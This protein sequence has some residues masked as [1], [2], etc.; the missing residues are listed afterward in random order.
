MSNSVLDRVDFNDANLKNA[1]LVNAVITGTTFDGTNLE[2]VDFEDALIGSQDANRLCRN[3]TLVG[4]SR[5][6]VGCRI[7]K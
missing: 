6:Q 7:S 3:P 5:Y 1:K 2:G 4:D